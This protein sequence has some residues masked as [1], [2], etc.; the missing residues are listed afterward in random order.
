MFTKAILCDAKGRL[1]APV[2]LEKAHLVVPSRSENPNEFPL[3]GIAKTN[4]NGLKRY[5][6][7]RADP[8]I[9]LVER[10]RESPVSADGL[11]V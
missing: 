4:F 8:G 5:I 11:E 2:E 6:K 1:E 9:P 10:E 3:A 7:G